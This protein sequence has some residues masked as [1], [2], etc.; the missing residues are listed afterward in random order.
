MQIK[1]FIP[2]LYMMSGGPSAVVFGKP[3][4]LALGWLFRL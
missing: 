3:N 1:A 4:K 2:Y